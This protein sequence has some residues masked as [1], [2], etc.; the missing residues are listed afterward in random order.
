MIFIIEDDKMMAECLASACQPHQSKIFSDAI[1]ATAYLS[2]QL[3]DLIFL[4]ILLT[5]PDGFTFLH[6]LVSY[7]DTAKIPVV[8]T[9]SLDLSGYNLSEYGVIGIL[10]KAKM[11][12]TDIKYYVQ[13]YTTN[14]EKN[15]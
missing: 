15:A 14:K 3:P 1:S 13:K 11:H 4:D 9:S 5:G 2:K 7:E 10:D 6:E 12:P 8:I